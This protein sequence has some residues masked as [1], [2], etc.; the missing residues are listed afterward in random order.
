MAE[1][2]RGAP[3]AAA[4]TA[5]VVA[6]ACAL[7]AADVEPALAIVR[8]GEREDDLSYE[9]AAMKRAEKAGI[10]VRREV[11]APESATDD[12]VRAVRA[13]SQDAAVHGILMFRPMPPGVDER[14]AASALAVQKD[15]DGMC[16]ASLMGVFTG[17]PVGF[18]PC[19]AEAVVELLARSGVS[20]SGAAVT[21]V[22][23]SLVIGRPVSML[24][25]ARDATVTM[26]HT[27]TRDLARR[28][29]EADV[30]VVAAGRAGV[31]GSGHVR[32]GQVVVDVGVN[33]E[34]A[35][36]RL[37][38]DVSF[39]EVEPIVRAITPVPGG[40]GAITTSILMKHVVQAAERA[41]GLETPWQ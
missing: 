18:A 25:Q 1:L 10:A 37:V 33:W 41:A 26:C 2:L 27:R 24:L 34:A 40:V 35:A 20:L 8:V 28:C 7:R 4:I 36:G 30:L 38:G 21:V 17:A 32:P 13:F 11:L 39:E 9:R 14:L 15:V 16:D 31:V 29:R 19:T 22:G 6:H 5:E 3:I 23:R 12:V